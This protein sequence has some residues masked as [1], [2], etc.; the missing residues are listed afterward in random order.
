MDAHL[1]W[2][3]HG[4]GADGYLISRVTTSKKM[5]KPEEMGAACVYLASE[6]AGFMTGATLNINGGLYYQ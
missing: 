5:G 2:I 3:R 6:N 1:E 4:D